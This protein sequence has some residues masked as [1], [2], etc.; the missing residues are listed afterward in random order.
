MKNKSLLTIFLIVF[1]DLLGF[2]IIIPLL[3][4][5]AE[6]FRANA[7]QI[8]FLTATYS[9]FQL[10]GSP[11]LGRLSDR[12]GRKKILIVSQ[13]GS[14]AGYLIL[15]FANSLPLLFISRIIDGITG[16]N[17][18]IAQAYIADITSTSDR[19]RGMGIIG[20]AF[21]LGFIFGPAIGGILSR[22]GYHWPA[23]F[24]FFI[25]LLTSFLTIFLLKET[26]KKQ[27]SHSQKTAFNIKEFI[28]VMRIYPIGL[29]IFIFFLLNTAFAFFTTNFPL[30]GQK[31][32]AMTPSQSGFIFAYIGLLAVIVQGLIMPRL[33]KKFPEKKLLSASIVFFII[34]FAIFPFIANYWLIFLPISL[35]PLGNGISGP[36]IQ[37]LASENVPKE[38]YGGTLGFLQSAGSAGRIAGPIIAGI[39]FYRLGKDSFFFLGLIMFIFIWSIIKIK[40]VK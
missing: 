35:L 13:L 16:G 31:T 9:I 38:E 33:L 4:F 34:S 5:W 28:K 6:K 27:A 24:A 10:I 12:F 23:L 18:S 11:I 2:G 21:G 17:I 20:A 32:F 19:A 14:A 29:L 3:P 1:V 30:W 37:S 22:Y 40:L 7:A 36:I 15:A 8:G 39:I 26:V 25:A